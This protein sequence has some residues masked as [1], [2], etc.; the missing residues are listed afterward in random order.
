MGPANVGWTLAWPTFTVSA[1]TPGRA[2]DRTGLRA[3]D[4]VQAV[5]GRLSPEVPI[6]SWRERILNLTGRSNSASG[7][8]G[9]SFHWRS[10]IIAQPL[11][12]V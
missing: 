6:G 2:M 10:A 1:V 7:V 11:E 8:D 5:N 12:K 9:S 4:I 3:G